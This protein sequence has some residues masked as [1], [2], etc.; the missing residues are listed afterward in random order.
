MVVTIRLIAQ[1]HTGNR[2]FEI[3]IV[4]GAA[5]KHGGALSSFIHKS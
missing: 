3:V 5:G 4:S 2:D 1:K